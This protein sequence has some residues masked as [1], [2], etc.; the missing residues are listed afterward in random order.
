[1]VAVS[2][3][4]PIYNVEKYLNQCLESIIQ[5]TFRDFEVIMVDNGSIDDSF[6]ICQMYTLK[7]ERFK[8]YRQ[9]KAGVAAVRNTCLKHVHGEYVAWI[10]SD[11]WID[12]DYLNKLVETQ[13][14]TQADIICIGNKTYMNDQIYLGSHQNKY[15]SYPGC[16]IPK[17]DAIGDIFFGMLSLISLWG[18]LI[19]K[20]LYRGFIFS[21]D[22]RYDDQGNKFKLYL[23]ANKIVGI[24]EVAYTYRVREESITQS[25]TE[26]LK[27]LEEQTA[28]L[29]KLFYYVEVADFETDYFY[30]R[31]LEWLTRKLSEEAVKN[32]SKCQSYLKKRLKLLKSRM[33]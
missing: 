19:K 30:H 4:M 33:I 1:M 2:I 6:N 24:P 28:N 12:N 20:S 13:K 31:Y 16:E 15:G 7:D 14:K 27:F 25:D 26:L 22:N 8:L 18:C 11:D 9:E 23:Q 3:C 21:E 17:K 32:D 29:E 5:Q 10:D